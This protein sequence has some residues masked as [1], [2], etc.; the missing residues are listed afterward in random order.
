MIDLT[1]REL[2][3]DTRLSTLERWYCRIFGIPIVG[4][5][6][7]LRTLARLLPERAERVLDA[8]C[9]R[10]VI[11]R[12][13]ARRYPEAQITAIDSDAEAQAANRTIAERGGLDNCRFEVADLNDFARPEGFDLVVS[14]D[15]L[16]HIEDDA[17]VI[18]RLFEALVPGGRLVVHV[19]H[20]YRRWPVFGWQE[21][22]DVPG[23]FRPGYH[24]PQLT[25]RLERAGF[26]IERCGYSYGF[27]E[28]L[29]NNIS[30]G[31][32]GAREQNKILYALLFPLL[33]GLAWLGRGGQPRMGAGAWAIAR[34][35]AS[36]QVVQG[37]LPTPTPG[38]GHRS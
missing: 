17:V 11:S 6:I 14:V 2:F 19:P 37:P 28:N 3:L 15:N 32:T 7:R 29:A 12:Y 30:Y 35:P 10:G 9:G 33:N 21:N 25:E 5:R 26:V 34:R 4:L 16:E 38:P 31:I 36:E 27:L 23:H 24:L 18:A 20:Y 1:G 13:L 22:F 8:G